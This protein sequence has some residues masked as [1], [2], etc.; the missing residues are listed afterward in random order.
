ME[1]RPS[2]G[3]TGMRIVSQGHG[4]FT[5]AIKGGTIDEVV[6]Q[7]N[8]QSP[9]GIQFFKTERAGIDWREERPP[10]PTIAELLPPPDTA[11]SS[12]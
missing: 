3:M 2:A 11:R 4:E 6:E 10:T 8:R 7:M 1:F 9:S 12:E 5:V